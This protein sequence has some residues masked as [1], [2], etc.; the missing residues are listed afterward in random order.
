[1]QRR[2]LN[3]S[4]N[5][6]TIVFIYACLALRAY[7]IKRFLY[8]FFH[9]ILLFLTLWILYTKLK[10]C[11]YQKIKTA[12]CYQHL[13]DF[14]KILFQLLLDIIFSQQ[15]ILY[16]KKA[17]LAIAVIFIRKINKGGNHLWL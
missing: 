3:D 6:C 14:I 13:S 2:I 8:I 15:V 7:E 11:L 17:A 4:A 12:Q 10:I 16:Y 9:N 1:M 5:K